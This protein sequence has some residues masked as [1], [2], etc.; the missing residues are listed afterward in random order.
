MTFKLISNKN[1]FFKKQSDWFLYRNYKWLILDTKNDSFID[2]NILKT[3]D[4]L[5]VL[6]SSEV[7]YFSLHKNEVYVKQGNNKNKLSNICVKAHI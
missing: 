6:P 3:F 4:I 7:F 1:I 2:E 5:P